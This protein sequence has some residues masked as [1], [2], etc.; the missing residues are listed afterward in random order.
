MLA[1]EMEDI[2]DDLTDEIQT[3]LK[4]S[5][6]MMGELGKRLSKLETRVEDLT[7][8][9]GKISE[10]TAEASSKAGR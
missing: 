7:K 3:G 9:L 2:K 1:L 5:A 6:N 10:V 8:A 4:D